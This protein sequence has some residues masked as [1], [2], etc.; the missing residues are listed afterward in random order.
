[1][2]KLLAPWSDKGTQAMEMIIE[3]M[4]ADTGVAFMPYVTP[5]PRDQRILIVSD[6]AGNADD[7]MRTYRGGA[8]AIITPKAKV[9]HT[10]MYEW[11]SEEILQHSTALE[12]ASAI[13]AIRTVHQR[14]IDGTLPPHDIV[15]VL[16]NSAAVASMRRNGAHSNS[17][18]DLITSWTHLQMELPARQRIFIFW[19]SREHEVE[20]ADALSKGDIAKADSM[21]AARDLPPTAAKAW[22]PTH[23]PA[24]SLLLPPTRT[25]LD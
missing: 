10:V 18:K 12:I 14:Q 23:P 22:R 6:A 15:V 3:L 1:M 25:Q 19:A 16:D 24:F 8:A 13:M 4:E 17:I 9:T 20:I 2:R 11:S 7:N 5:P 21:L